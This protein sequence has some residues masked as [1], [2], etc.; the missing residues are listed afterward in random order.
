MLYRA[1]NEKIRRGIWIFIICM[2]S[3]QKYGKK[4]IGKAT[5]RGLDAA[6]TD[7]KKLLIKR[8]KQE[9]NWLQKS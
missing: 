9:K 8:L 3:V 6:K 5:K 4:L 7:S 2:K 1:K